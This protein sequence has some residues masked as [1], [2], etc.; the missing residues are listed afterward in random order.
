MAQRLERIDLGGEGGGEYFSS[1]QIASPFS[2]NSSPFFST[3][4]GG[5]STP[6]TSSATSS[7]FLPWAF[8]RRALIF[9]VNNSCLARKAAPKIISAWPPEP[10]PFRPLPPPPSLEPHSQLASPHSHL[11]P[12]PVSSLEQPPSLIS[13]CMFGTS[14]NRVG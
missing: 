6:T 4:L 13:H 9:S 10:Q 8:S 1:S 11:Q 14:L 7:N 3:S 12:A 2:F 5:H